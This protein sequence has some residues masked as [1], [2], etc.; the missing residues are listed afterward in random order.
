MRH[1]AVSEFDDRLSRL[2]AAV[3]AGED[4]A[5]TRDGRDVV[6]LVAIQQDQLARQRAAVEAAYE[7]GQEILRTQGPTTSEERRRWIEE[8]RR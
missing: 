5:F 8:D 7:L 3:E 1:V 2:V 4:V 6:R